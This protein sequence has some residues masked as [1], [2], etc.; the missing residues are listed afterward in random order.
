MSW[1]AITEDALKVAKVAALV[2]ASRTAALGAGQTDPMPL[3]I[4]DVTA[5][6]RAEVMGHPSNVVDVDTT[7]IPSELLSLG[8]RM[9]IRQMQSRLQLPLNDDEKNEEKNDLRYL[10][11]ISRGELTISLPDHPAVR[12]MQVVLPPPMIRARRPLFRREQEDGL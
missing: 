1:L 9:A 4:A 2:D 10:E 5:R 12:N 6:L 7:L 11:R 3:S 8:C